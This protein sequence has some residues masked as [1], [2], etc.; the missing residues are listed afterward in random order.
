MGKIPAFYQ[1]QMRECVVC[2]YWWEELSGKII[3]DK[4]GQWKCRETC[5]D[6]NDVRKSNK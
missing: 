5:V 6:I 1:G 4:D 3:K 2:G